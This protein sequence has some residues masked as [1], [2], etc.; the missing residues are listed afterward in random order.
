MPT[1]FLVGFSEIPYIVYEIV[2][3]CS[4]FAG[5]RAGDSSDA[6][7]D[8]RVVFDRGCHVETFK[9]GNVEPFFCEGVGGEEV[10]VFAR[11]HALYRVLPLRFTFFRRHFPRNHHGLGLHISRQQG[12]KG[13]EVFE[14]VGKD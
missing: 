8:Y 9:T 13:F 6:L 10:S 7:N 4:V 1:P 5:E 3:D 12:H 14:P 2:S 11:P